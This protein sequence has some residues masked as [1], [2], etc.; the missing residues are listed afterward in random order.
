MQNSFLSISA[1]YIIAFTTQH[2]GTSVLD[3]YKYTLLKKHKH[4]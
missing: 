4:F 2:K 1:K 3:N